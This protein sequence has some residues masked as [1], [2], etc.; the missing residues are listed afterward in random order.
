MK[1][2]SFYLFLSCHRLPMQ[3]IIPF[4]ACG[5]WLGFPTPCP[6][7]APSVSVV[8]CLMGKHIDKL[9]I[10]GSRSWTEIFGQ[11]HW[12]EC[13]FCLR[14]NQLAQLFFIKKSLHCISVN[15]PSDCH[16]SAI[17]VITWKI[18]WQRRY[19]IYPHRCLTPTSWTGI[20]VCQCSFP[21]HCQWSKAQSLTN[22]VGIQQ[23]NYIF[24]PQNQKPSNKAQTLLLLLS[25]PPT[26]IEIFI[27]FLFLLS[28]KYWFEV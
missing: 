12:H 21:F 3:T 20:E 15:N 17:L 25:L 10:I 11:C 22:V 24:P 7:T 26:F 28:V 2:D 1:P 14:V 5:K 8:A 4:Q 27:I 18:G 6:R 9:E 16:G 13:T 19:F 23:S